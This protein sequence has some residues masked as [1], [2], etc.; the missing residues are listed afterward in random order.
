MT[1]FKYDVVYW[2]EDKQAS[3]PHYGLLFAENYNNAIDLLDKFYD[4]EH[5]ESIQLIPI[6]VGDAIPVTEFTDRKA[7]KEVI[8]NNDEWW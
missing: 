7:L 3:I 1:T 8:K 2:N 4:I 5:L 6:G